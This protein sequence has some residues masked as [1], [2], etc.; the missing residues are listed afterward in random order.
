M[1]PVVS[2]RDFLKHSAAVAG[3]LVVAPS[4]LAQE[5]ELLFPISLAQWS[6]HRA[7][8]RGGKATLDPLKFAEISRKDYDIYAIEYVNQF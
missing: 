1:F 6:L 8:G 2:R 4:L 5:K 7:F 3:G